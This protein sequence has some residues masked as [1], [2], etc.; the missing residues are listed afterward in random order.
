MVETLLRPREPIAIVRLNDLSEA[1][2][3]AEALLD[4]GI[5]TLEFTLT[6][7]EALGAV[8]KVRAQL[9]DRAV[10]GAG[11]VLDA[12]NARAAVL[13]GA[14][15]LVS[16]TVEPEVIACGLEMGV[17]VV[18]GALT[19]TEILTA[20]RLG[21]ELIKLFP[22]RGLGPAYVRDVLAPLPDVRLVP[23][24]GVS[25]ENC[26]EFLRAGAYTVGLGSNL[27][28]KRLVA[29]GD[30]GAISALAERYV[31]ACARAY[32]ESG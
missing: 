22:A 14:Q 8:E 6:N 31:E 30:W 7:P 29:G 21:A 26:G 15:F 2:A 25:V 17:P 3:I 16:P 20:H 28:D 4:G 10:V 13:S 11:T 19:P 27:V 5:F 23:T 12:R 1:L 32:T 9:G 18:P 24:G